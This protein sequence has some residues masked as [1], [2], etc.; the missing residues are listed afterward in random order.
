MRNLAIVVF[1]FAFAALSFAQTTD[2]NPEKPLRPVK[3]RTLTS[4]ELPAVR[5][6]F[7]KEFEYA[8]G[9]RFVL[10][11]V[12]T[13]EQHFFIDAGKDGL[14]RRMY[15]VQFEG[16]LPNNTNSYTYK[17]NKTVNIGGLDFIADTYA[18]NIRANPGRPDSD[19]ALARNFLAQRG[20]RLASDE[21]LSQRFL[22]YIG[23]DKRNELMIIYLEDMSPLGVTAADLADGGKDAGKRAGIFDAMLARAQK[24]LTFTH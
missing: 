22:H 23:E 18:R 20:Y 12:A 9:H 14:I 6:K 17:G 2:T 4:I 7:G 21:T 24:G 3:G 8:G 5:I 15:W 1:L 10:Y 11:N 13:A 19:G 16:Y